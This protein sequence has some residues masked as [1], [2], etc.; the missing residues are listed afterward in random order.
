M[1]RSSLPMAPF[2]LPSYRRLFSFAAEREQ[3]AASGIPLRGH[4][5]E[6]NR[7]GASGDL[8][9]LSRL[10]MQ[11]HRIRMFAANTSPESRDVS[12]TLHFAPARLSTSVF[13]WISRKRSLVIFA[14]AKSA[15]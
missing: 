2:P 14:A 10:L 9:T 13:G 5:L 1:K 7:D 8:V 4:L 11:G 12:R 3:A 6:S 15:A